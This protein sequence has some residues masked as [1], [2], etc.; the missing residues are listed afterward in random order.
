ML[1]DVVRA[2]AARDFIAAAAAAEAE[3]ARAADRDSV[4]TLAEVLLSRPQLQPMFPNTSDLLAAEPFFARVC[5]SLEHALGPED[6]CVARFRTRVA[7]VASS[8]GDYPAA[9]AM[10][11]H[12][13]A[14][15]SRVL[16][17]NDI[18]TMMLRSNLAIQHRNAHHPERADA[19]FAEVMLC[20][21]VQPI[22]DDLRRLG[23]HVF[24]V[25]RPW[26]DNCRAWMYFDVVLDVDTLRHRLRL[27]D[28]V[29][30]H[31]HRGTV[32]GAEQG[33]VC[34]VDHDAVMGVHPDL[35]GSGTPVIS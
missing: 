13:L 18:Q 15:L 25:S 19:L 31:R 23:L 6:I 30:L 2:F 1:D 3:I 21:H 12:S 28:C 34:R 5:A 10:L 17:P 33:L 27:A 35:A 9:A 29:D 4:V 16:G 20:E 22:V 7:S 26:S 32:D 24:D 8:R 14:T 11:A